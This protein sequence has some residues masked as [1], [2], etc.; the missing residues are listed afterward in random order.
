[1]KFFELQLRQISLNFKTYRCNLKIES[2]GPKQYGQA[3]TQ[4][5][6]EVSQTDKIVG[7]PFISNSDVFDLSYESLSELRCQDPRCASD[8]SLLLIS[9][10]KYIRWM[11]KCATSLENWMSVKRFKSSN[12]SLLPI[13]L[14]ASF[15][16][17][18]LLGYCKMIKICTRPLHLFVLV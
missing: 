3:R 11:L 13:T 16:H 14:N 10:Y 4:H 15:G 5:S 6:K 7:F 8:F 2:L 9:Q 17:I 1:M 12:T 18:Q